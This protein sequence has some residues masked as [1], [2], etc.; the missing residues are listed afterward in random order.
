MI[1]DDN[2][3]RCMML[4]VTAEYVPHDKTQQDATIQHY[5]THTL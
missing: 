4:R 5:Y 1:C 2:I 3:H